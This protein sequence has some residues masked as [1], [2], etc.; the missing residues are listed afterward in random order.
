MHT[1]MCKRDCRK[2]TTVRTI[3]D[4]LCHGAWQPSES[5]FPVKLF[6][7][8][9][10]SWNN[11][12]PLTLLNIST[13]YRAGPCK[14]SCLEFLLKFPADAAR[15]SSSPEYR[16]EGIR[17]ACEPR[18][19]IGFQAGREQSW[20]ANNKQRDH[21]VVPVSHC[22]SYLESRE[23]S[24]SPLRVCTSQW[25]NLWLLSPPHRVQISWSGRGK[26]L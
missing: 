1:S 14:S 23:I 10:P 16:H 4:L 17:E 2:K 24:D 18:S 5:T 26:K 12:L 22:P 13:V 8:S 6:P 21:C 25:G 9:F 7:C 20:C 15:S 11:Y 19:W 3:W